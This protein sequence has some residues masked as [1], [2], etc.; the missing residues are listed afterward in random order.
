MFKNNS[1]NDNKKS[2]LKYMIPA[3]IA[4]L[5]ICVFISVKTINNINNNKKINNQVT[6]I[7]KMYDE[8]DKEKDRDKKIEILNNTIDKFSNSKET[9]IINTYKSNLKKM[10]NYFSD[11]YNKIIKEND[12]TEEL[13]NINSKDDIQK[14]IDN[15]NNLKEK[16]KD[17]KVLNKKNTNKVNDKIDTLIKSYNDRYDQIDQAEKES[18][19]IRLE[20]ESKAAAEAASKAAEEESIRLQK[21]EEARKAEEER[22]NSQTKA[23]VPETTAEVAANNN[24]NYNNYEETQP[25]TEAPTEAPAQN[26]YSGHDHSSWTDAYLSDGTWV[27]RRY[28]DGCLEDENGI[29][30]IDE[31]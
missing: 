7:N 1:N 23:Y 19:S 28:I 2:Y 20:E 18:E 11:D 8:F 9:K 17:E 10:K 5:I 13:D 30:T 29:A 24:E 6:S 22:K 12:K 27:G 3:I 4:I 15:L 14:L 31:Y 16:I 25:A 26:N 21:E